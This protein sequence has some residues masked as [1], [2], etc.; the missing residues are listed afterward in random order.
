MVW[1]R[2]CI[3][4]AEVWLTGPLHD[5]LHRRHRSLHCQHSCLQRAA[6]LGDLEMEEPHHRAVSTVRR[7]AA[8]IGQ[9]HRSQSVRHFADAQRRRS[10]SDDGSIV[11]S[12]LGLATHEVKHLRGTLAKGVASLEGLLHLDRTNDQHE[13]VGISNADD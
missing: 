10:L 6:L 11:W 12:A 7:S 9:Q 2:S 3:S 8:H 1:R 13:P 5:I 4:T